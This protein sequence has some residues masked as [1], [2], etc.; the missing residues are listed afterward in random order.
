M[1][2]LGT[3]GEK[4]K[5]KVIRSDVGSSSLCLARLSIVVLLYRRKGRSFTR[6]IRAFF[7]RTQERDRQSG[8]SLWERVWSL[9]WPSKKLRDEEKDLSRWAGPVSCFSSFLSSNQ[10]L[11]FLP[12]LPPSSLSLSPPS[13]PLVDYSGNH[14]RSLCIVP[15]TQRTNERT[16]RN[17]LCELPSSLPALLF[18]PE[19]IA[20]LKT[21]SPPTLTS[22]HTPSLFPPTTYNLPHHHDLLFLDDFDSF[23][24][25]R[26]DDVLLSF[27]QE[28]VPLDSLRGFRGS[29]SPF[30]SPPLWIS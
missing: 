24:L 17:P 16:G 5:R 11:P 19:S 29:H 8:L 25:A 22:T 4:V 12:S 27:S 21:S 3:E 26:R 15:E 20:S 23:L 7:V 9:W 10:L 13:S 6:P 30:K 28:H 14:F 1:K 18:V 2:Q